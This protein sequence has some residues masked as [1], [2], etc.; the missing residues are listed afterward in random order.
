MSKK[1]MDDELWARVEQNRLREEQLRAPYLI[2]FRATPDE[3]ER[4]R[5][6]GVAETVPKIEDIQEFG[7]WLERVTREGVRFERYL[8]RQGFYPKL[9]KDHPLGREC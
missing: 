4:R 2:A 8:V 3:V 7:E 6:E 1:L 5:T 9:S